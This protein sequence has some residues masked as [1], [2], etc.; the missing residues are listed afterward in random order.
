MVGSDR[1]RWPPA[2]EQ[3]TGAQHLRL[4]I[5]YRPHFVTSVKS[6][7]ERNVLLGA[8]VGLTKSRE[9]Q[10]MAAALVD[11]DEVVRVEEATVG[12]ADG[13]K[14]RPEVRNIFYKRNQVQSQII[15]DR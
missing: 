12:E 15:I 9:G 5:A 11:V 2:C 3:P 13:V 14:V 10:E 4:Q 8:L 7:A 6:H 1:G